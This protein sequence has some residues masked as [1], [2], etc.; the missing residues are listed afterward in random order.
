MVSSLST[1][2][3]AQGSKYSPE[4]DMPKIA[5]GKSISGSFE[6]EQHIAGLFKHKRELSDFTGDTQPR[7]NEQ[8]NARSNSPSNPTNQVN[9]ILS[10]QM[11]NGGN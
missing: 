10:E 3:G 6:E 2:I 8:F 9:Q 4:R 7:F 5:A 11:S 1:A